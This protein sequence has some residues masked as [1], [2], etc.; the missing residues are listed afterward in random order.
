[1]PHPKSARSSTLGLEGRLIACASGQLGVFT[2]QQAAEVGLSENALHWRKRAG[3]IVP[4]FPGVYRLAAVEESRE[5]QMLAGCLAVR[6]SVVGG[7]S[8][9]LLHGLPVGFAYAGKPTL[10][11]PNQTTVRL[12]G[13][14][15]HRTRHPYRTQPWLTVRMTQVSSTLI[16]LASVLSQTDLARCLDYAIAQ[17]SVS[18]AR[19]L[20]EAEARPVSRFVG[21]APLFAELHAWVGQQ[22]VHRSRYE[23]KVDRW[24]RESSLPH[25]TPNF[26]VQILGRNT[27]VEVDRAWP[28]ARV[29]LEIS[30]FFTH[31]SAST[32]RRD[33]QRRVWLQESRW[34]IVEAT[35]EH[36][37]N[38]QSF[39]PVIESL[40]RL[41]GVC[42]FS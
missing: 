4:I 30:P 27:S 19:V 24:I 39:A 31:G 21:R 16:S 38:R 12:S 10:I 6:N 7:V 17:G 36:L 2:V 15:V 1:M 29:A 18:V 20:R 40:E 23:Q 9:A 32:Q 37:I 5:Q 42:A 33:M 14:D 34:R 41:M 3:L 25:S 22:I 35:D 26:K 28:A 13:V 8:A 11:V